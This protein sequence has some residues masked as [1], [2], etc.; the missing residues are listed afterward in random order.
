MYNYPAPQQ[1]AAPSITLLSR[2]NRPTAATYSELLCRV[3][4][5]TKTPISAIACAMS[6]TIVTANHACC[7]PGNS[8]RPAARGP[9]TITK[10]D[11]DIAIPIQPGPI[12]D[13]QTGRDCQSPSLTI[14]FRVYPRIPP[15]TNMYAGVLN[16]PICAAADN[17]IPNSTRTIGSSDRKILPML[18][19]RTY[20]KLR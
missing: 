1:K 6:R 3:V 15:T 16:N 20:P 8:P 9:M 19:D 17:F 18:Q 2:H 12:A 7:G 14:L 4:R 5:T 13:L 11:I 10:A